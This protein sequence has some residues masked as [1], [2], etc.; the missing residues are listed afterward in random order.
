MNQIPDDA[1]TVHETFDSLLSIKIHKQSV[2][3]PILFLAWFLV[4]YSRIGEHTQQRQAQPGRGRPSLAYPLPLFSVPPPPCPSSPF[5][6][7]QEA[8][9][10]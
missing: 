1:H 4:L 7:C 5:P 2:T 10:R 3:G 9:G 6:M 8:S